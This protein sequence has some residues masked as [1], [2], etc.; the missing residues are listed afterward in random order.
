MMKAKQSTS[1]K[2]TSFDGLTDYATAR[3]I[4]ISAGDLSV[5]VRREVKKILEKNRNNVLG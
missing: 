1:A 5:V 3:A 4:A 2:D